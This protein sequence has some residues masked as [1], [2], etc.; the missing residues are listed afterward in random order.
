MFIMSHK[1]M[2]VTL[3]EYRVSQVKLLQKSR[4]RKETTIT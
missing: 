3:P 1:A 2:P 4:E